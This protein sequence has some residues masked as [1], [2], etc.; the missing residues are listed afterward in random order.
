M[1]QPKHCGMCGDTHHGEC[2]P[3]SFNYFQCKNCDL[4]QRLPW[5]VLAFCGWG[6]MHCGC[7]KRSEEVWRSIT[8]DEYEQLGKEK[9][10]GCK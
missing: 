6:E 9:D 7:G 5:D 10:N 2:K 1:E 8:F 3:G 4:L